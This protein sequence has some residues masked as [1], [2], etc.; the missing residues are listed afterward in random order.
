MNKYERIYLKAKGRS[1]GA[2]A[3][4]LDSAIAALAVD[5]EEHTG[6]R[7]EVSG[8]FG[9]RAEVMIKAGDTYTIITPSFED[10]GFKLYYDTGERTQTYQPNTLGDWNGLNNISAPL[11]DAFEEIVS[12]MTRH[13]EE[14]HQ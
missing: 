8:P 1:K 2:A 13:R 4:W 10:G 11:P 7:V 14:I 6:K 9:L 12:I 3:S 5:V